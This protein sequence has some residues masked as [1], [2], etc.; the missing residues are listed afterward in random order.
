MEIGVRNV[1]ATLLDHLVVEIKLIRTSNLE[2][3]AIE[4]GFPSGVYSMRATG[5]VTTV[6]LNTTRIFS[7]YL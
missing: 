4:D 2:D 5:G 6:M 3:V 1:L 7:R